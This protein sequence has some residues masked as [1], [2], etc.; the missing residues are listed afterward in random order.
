MRDKKGM[1]MGETEGGEEL[2]IVQ[3][4]EIVIRILFM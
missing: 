4:E 1:G 2:G 3:E